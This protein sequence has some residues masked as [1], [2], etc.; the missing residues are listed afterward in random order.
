ML[1]LLQMID[2]HIPGAVLVAAV[3]GERTAFNAGVRYP[4]HRHGV[5][6][7]PTWLK[8]MSLVT[9]SHVLN[10]TQFMLTENRSE[11]IETENRGDRSIEVL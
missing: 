11:F 8:E 3:G 7:H 9:S 6:F 10:K 2:K 4:A 1:N 5:V